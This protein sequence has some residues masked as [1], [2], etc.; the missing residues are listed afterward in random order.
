MSNMQLSQPARCLP[1]ATASLLWLLLLCGPRP[2]AAQ[3]KFARERYPIMD[4]TMPLD[5]P[6]ALSG[7]F[8][9]VRGRHFHAGTDFRTGGEEGRPVYAVADGRVV[10]INVSTSGYGK[11]LYVAHPN[12]VTSVYAHLQQFNPEI[13][14][15]V[16]AQQ[17][18]RKNYEVQLFPPPGR[19]N[20]RQGDTIARSGNTGSSGGPHLHFELRL[21]NGSLPYNSY[22]SG[23]RHADSTPPQFAR[24]YL[25][26]INATNFEES[27]A[28]RRRLYFKANG[29]NYHLNIDTLQ[30]GTFVGFGIEARDPVNDYSLMCSLNE[31]KMRVDGELVYYYNMQRIGFDETA[32]A[33]AHVDS[34]FRAHGGRR[35]MLLFTLPGNKLSRYQ[36]ER[37]GYLSLARGE[38]ANV[39][40]EATDMAGNS[41]F[42]RF[43]ARGTGQPAAYKSDTSRALIPWREG[44]RLAR[45]RYRLEVPA[46]ALYY[47]IA[48]REYLRDTLR[49]DGFPPTVTFGNAY[50]PLHRPAT[51]WLDASKIPM[52]L[53]SKCFLAWV[54]SK[55]RAHYVGPV[56]WEGNWAAA[57]IRSFSSYTLRADT[58]PPIISPKSLARICG[59]NLGAADAISV[60]VRDEQTAIKR[61]DAYIDGRWV[62]MEWE[63]KLNTGVY[64]F[65]KR[66]ETQGVSHTLRI[67]AEDALGN[68]AVHECRFVR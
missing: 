10:R 48:L 65:D 3:D 9:E 47:D 39:E 11:A 53:R 34:Y 12:G 21:Q 60:N 18:R 46:E 7:S 68:T 35:V 15:W 57:R 41:S 55:A 25:Y 66:C 29:A 22:L 5:T 17:Y 62:L 61:V 63:P 58:V 24:F 43:V 54:D 4:V 59:R 2:V 28:R 6:L 8:G 26:E 50:A 36:T 19:F 40:I 42:M 14:A 45:R 33:E 20:V 56:Q 51:L 49:A 13:E 38:S 31:L 23:I 32:Y 64:H 16:N 52:P 27:F 1:L 37:G 44:A 30:V 67:V